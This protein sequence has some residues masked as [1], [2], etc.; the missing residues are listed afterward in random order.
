MKYADNHTFFMWLHCFKHLQ[1]E[2]TFEQ[3][4]SV[5]A[6]LFYRLGLLQD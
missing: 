4:L 1:T 5:R 6:P 2:I 3:Q